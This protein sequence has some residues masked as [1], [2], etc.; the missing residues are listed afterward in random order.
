M[1]LG[2]L[3]NFDFLTVWYYLL[4]EFVFCLCCTG[5]WVLWSLH[6]Q[7]ERYFTPFIFQ[8]SEHTQLPLRGENTKDRPGAKR[9]SQI[10][11]GF[12]PF[13]R[14]TKVNT[15]VQRSSKS[16]QGKA[17]GPGVWWE[18][19]VPSRAGE[20]INTPILNL[21]RVGGKRINGVNITS[22]WIF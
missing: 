1:S 21:C 3:L 12:Q 10:P 15:L 11:G 8:T 2:K 13:L 19:A 14:R 20:G 22:I 17:A 9:V 7:T 18:A 4:W 6:I 5:T 16:S